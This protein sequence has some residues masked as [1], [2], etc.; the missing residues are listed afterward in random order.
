MS[1]KVIELGGIS[2]ADMMEHADEARFS[3][4]DETGDE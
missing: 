4:N 1:Q 2:V 3:I